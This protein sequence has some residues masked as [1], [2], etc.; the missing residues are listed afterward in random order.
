MTRHLV[1]TGRGEKHFIFQTI[2]R[3]AAERR[4]GGHLDRMDIAVCFT[5]TTP[6]NLVGRQPL[7]GDL[8]SGEGL[9][10]NVFEVTNCP[11]TNNIGPS[12]G[13]DGSK[14]GLVHFTAALSS[15]QRS[16]R[17]EVRHSQMWNF[18]QLNAEESS[19][20]TLPLPAGCSQVLH[21]P[22]SSRFFRLQC[23]C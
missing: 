7:S 13:G 20:L 2:G 10:L 5:G 8:A 17:S 3:E 9:D 22:E 16:E 18:N 1:L 15:P 23:L 4:T 6:D 11:T 14:T 21:Q 12:Q 19:L